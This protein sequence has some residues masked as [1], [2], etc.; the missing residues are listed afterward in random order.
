[1]EHLI[2]THGFF[3]LVILVGIC[4]LAAA[5]WRSKKVS[6]TPGM[7]RAPI[8]YL[9]L[10]PLL[11]GNDPARGA[12]NDKKAVISK[13]VIFGW[14]IVLLLVALTMVFDW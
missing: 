4:G 6:R 9:L 10:W 7:K 13:R 12:A 1:M 3:A 2:K 11:F 8:D 14:L 5:F